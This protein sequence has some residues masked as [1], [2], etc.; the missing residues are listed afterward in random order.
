MEDD[1]VLILV[2]WETSH[3][4]CPYKAARQW[5]WGSSRVGNLP[6][7]LRKKCL[8]RLLLPQQQ[9]KVRGRG[10]E[11]SHIGCQWGSSSFLR[12]PWRCR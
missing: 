12:M 1:P 3:A 5:G 2:G 9:E 8:A 6:P 10:R 7:S 11:A 4:T